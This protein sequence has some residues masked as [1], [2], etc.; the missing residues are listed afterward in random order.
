ML[1]RHAVFFAAR[2]AWA[3][4]GKR[5]PAR[6]E[7]I[8]MTTRSSMSVKALLFFMFVL[9]RTP[10]GPSVGRSVPFARIRRYGG[11]TL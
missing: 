8:A 5:I 10:S 6:I 9:A 1:E 11:S 4:A 3:N 2:L 7:M